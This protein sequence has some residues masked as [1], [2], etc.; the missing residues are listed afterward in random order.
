MSRA[1]IIAMA[2]AASLALAQESDDS[3]WAGCVARWMAEGAISSSNGF[4]YSRSLTSSALLTPANGSSAFGPIG[5][6]RVSVANNSNYFVFAASTLATIKGDFTFSLWLMRTA[7][8]TA[9]ARIIDFTANG[10]LWYNNG[11][12]ILTLY[13]PPNLGSPVTP[14]NGWIDLTWVRTT[15]TWSVY[16]NGVLFASTA[17]AAGTPAMTSAG[18]VCGGAG[19]TTPGA[20]LHEVAFWNRALLPAEVRQLYWQTMPRELR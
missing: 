18:S 5:G 16:S 19:A 6:D 4:A 8:W 13:G 14:L 10:I 2:F 1:L 20:V 17:S 3:L 12:T 7:S 11:N 15:N 9:N